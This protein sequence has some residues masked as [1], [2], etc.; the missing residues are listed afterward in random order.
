MAPETAIPCWN[1]PK[2][3]FNPLQGTS[4]YRLK[5]TDFNG[6]SYYSD[7][8]VVKTYPVLA[9]ELNL[10]PNP[11]DGAFH[12]LLS[13]FGDEEILVVLRDMA[14]KR[15]LFESNNYFYR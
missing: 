1:I 4:Y 12:L 8:K 14:G 9:G 11:T 13:G 15:I 10:Y 5:Q 6:I 7:I 3:I 2:P